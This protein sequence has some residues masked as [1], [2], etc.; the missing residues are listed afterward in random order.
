MVPVFHFVAIITLTSKPLYI[1]FNIVRQKD[2]VLSVAVQKIKN[3][4]ILM[5][6]VI[7]VTAQFSVSQ[8]NTEN[9]RLNA[10]ANYL[11]AEYQIQIV[12]AKG[13]KS[14]EVLRLIR[15]KN[16]VMYSSGG[17][18]YVWD[19]LTKGRLKLTKY[20]ESINKG[21]EYQPSD[22]SLN[23]DQ[24][25]WQH[26]YQILSDSQL[27]NLEGPEIEWC[28]HNKACDKVL[29]KTSVKSMD[30]VWLQD[31][32]LPREIKQTQGSEQLHWKL[33]SLQLN[34]QQV[35]DIFK[36]LNHYQ[37]I[38]VADIGDAE[39]EE[40]LDRLVNSDFSIL[41]KRALWCLNK[42]SIKPISH[43]HGSHP[44]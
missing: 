9:T 14:R 36:P 41:I 18:Y 12:N 33:T 13:D 39:P 16:Q 21:I 30:V 4:T 44:H 43:A 20:V 15:N 5:M 8:S 3:L 37:L 27:E 26:K 29:D 17:V 23:N 7:L 40:D 19:H 2:R 1:R 31:I 22:L 34:S 11:V 38:D 10:D 6:F 35:S 28:E 42:Q 32:K 24:N 25:H